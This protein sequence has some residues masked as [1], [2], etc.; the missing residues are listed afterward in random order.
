MKIFK[1]ILSFIVIALIVWFVSS[2]KTEEAPPVV[3]SFKDCELA[4]YLVMES[5]PRQCRTPDGRTYA[6]ELPEKI[7]YTKSSNNLIRVANP[8]PGAVTG[9]EF[10]VIGEARGAWYFEASFPVQVLD[11]DGKVLATGIA[12]AQSDWMTENFVP[13]KAAIK[14]PESYIGPATLVLHKDNPSGL[15]END[16]SISL[17]IAIE[18]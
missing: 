2:R 10:L 4:G 3:L 13:F 9:K 1:L 12:Q 11:K 7:T 8:F 14:V 16:A 6:E 18:Y 17:P 5:Y 15:P